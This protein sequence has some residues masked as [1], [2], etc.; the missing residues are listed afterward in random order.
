MTGDAAAVYRA[1]VSPMTI[2]ALPADRVAIQDDIW[3]MFLRR[4]RRS[5]LSL[6]ASAC[7][8]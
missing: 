4:S 5:S 7:M 8:L 1:F 3:A 2:T 6:P